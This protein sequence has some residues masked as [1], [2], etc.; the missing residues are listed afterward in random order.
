MKE[1]NQIIKIVKKKII[2][3]ACIVILLLSKLALYTEVIAYDGQSAINDRSEI[4]INDEEIKVLDNKN[5][6]KTVSMEQLNW[7]KDMSLSTGSISITNDGKTVAM[8]G[9]KKNEGKNSI[10]IIPEK[11]QGQTLQFDYNI[12]FGDSFI[13]A[14][15]LLKVKKT[16][17]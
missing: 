5:L 7:T 2:A 14:G 1:C 8:T 15:V 17:G 11:P 16:R 10:Y 9:N 13:A 12:D 6:R 3:I 4:T